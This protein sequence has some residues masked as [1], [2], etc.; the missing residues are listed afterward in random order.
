M[1][2]AKING[3]NLNFQMEGRGEPLLLIGGFNSNQSIWIGQI[4]EFKKYFRVITFDN[5]GAGKS[6]KLGPY[7]IR[8]MADDAAGLLHHLNIPQAHILGVSMG[9]LI[10]QEVA[11]NYPAKVSRLILAATYSHIDETC[12]PTSAAV[13]A[14]EL[15]V[16]GMLDVMLDLMINKPAYRL[17]LIPLMRIK[18]K[19]AN[20]AAI[21]EKLR[22]SAKYNRKNEMPLIQAPTLVITGTADRL[23][24]PA[25]S[26]ILAGLIRDAKLVRINGGSHLLFLEMRKRFNQLVLDFLREMTAAP[27][28]VCPIAS[29]PAVKY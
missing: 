2:Q 19:L 18:N 15:P 29:P 22:A 6:D 12:G 28:L 7:S 21:T 23:I 27:D 24:K 25:S 4:P 20:T 16:H 26:E 17:L 9:G 3:I 5:R 13:K 1:P 14:A 8:T 11:V 10:A